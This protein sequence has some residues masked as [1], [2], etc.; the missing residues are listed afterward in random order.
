MFWNSSGGRLGRKYSAAPTARIAIRPRIDDNRFNTSNGHTRLLVS[1][2]DRGSSPRFVYS[3]GV[4]GVVPYVLSGSSVV[5][6]SFF[7]MC[8]RNRVL[9]VVSEGLD[10]VFGCVSSCRQCRSSECDGDDHGCND[11]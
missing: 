7:M 2:A 8:G 10:R 1:F 4:Y 9:L 3:W 6:F 11:Q 5:G